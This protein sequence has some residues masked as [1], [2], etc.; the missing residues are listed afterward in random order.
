MAGQGTT[1]TMLGMT[2]TVTET[3]LP[4]EIP[5]CE[6]VAQ[7]GETTVRLRHT[8]GAIDGPRAEITTEQLQADLDAARQRAA[9]EAAWR[10]DLR[11]KLEQVK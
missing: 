3:K 1:V 5:A 10:E 7:A 8:F 6:I 9:N 11:V 4:G 2:V